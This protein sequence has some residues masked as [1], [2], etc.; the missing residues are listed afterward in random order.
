[1]NTAKYHPRCPA[2]GPW[3]WI[4]R[5]RADAA[6]AAGG[7]H[8]LLAYVGLCS[9][10]ARAGGRDVFRASVANLSHATGLSARTMS[11]NLAILE[12]AGL[13]D[14]RSGR[15]GGLGGAHVANSYCI[16]HPSRK[17]VAK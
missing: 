4:N 5:D 16:P 13:V 1:M 14:R 2:D 11:K 6:L 17:E 9:C 12:A 10:H 15:H 7:A 3:F 8:G